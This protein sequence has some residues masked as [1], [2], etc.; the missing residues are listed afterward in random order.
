MRVMTEKG[1]ALSF[2]TRRMLS[3]IDR[4]FGS[5][6]DKVHAI[7]QRALYNLVLNNRSTTSL[8]ERSIEQ[9][10]NPFRHRI[11][12][13]HFSVLTKVLNSFEDYQL[14][15]WKV[16]GALIFVLGN[17]KGE[18]RVQSARLL[19]LLERRRDENSGIQDFDIN[20]S[21]RTTA[22]YKQAAYDI[23]A[24][25][26]RTHQELTFHIFSLFCKHFRSV[27]KDVQRQMVFSILPWVQV[28][29]LQID[30]NDKPTPQ[31]SMVLANL[32]EITFKTS[33]LLH[34][35]V[36]ALWQALATGHPGNVQLVLDF[37]ISL[38]SERKDQAVVFYAKQVIVYM[39]HGAAGAKVVEFLLLKIT[40]KNMVF[41]HKE[42][43]PLA[44]D[45]GGLPYL[46][47]LAETLPNVNRTVSVTV[48]R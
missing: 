13:S 41:S 19:Q 35:E 48:M 2:D 39:A 11:L 31:S 4:I 43:L 38:C 36:Q 28:I 17:D 25:L 22:V 30:T 27:D 8:L 1:E 6:V 33:S 18:V 26:S 10:F 40:P 34:N 20:I 14:P 23:S 42:S 21:D 24:R 3:W 12:E 7:G 47:D 5:D 29:E 16:L 9:C 32:L 15:F 45:G 46:A 37:V 44:G